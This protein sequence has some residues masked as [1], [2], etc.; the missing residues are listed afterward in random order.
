MNNGYKVGSK[1]VEKGKVFRVFK[2]EDANINGKKDKIIHYL[3][4]FKNIT[5][6][7]L[8]CS[9]PESSIGTTLLRKP[10][11]KEKIN[12]V[13]AGLSKRT[14]YV[15]PVDAVVAKTKLNLNDIDITARVLRKYWLVKKKNVDTF[16]KTKRDVLD[17]AVDRLV[18][19]VAYVVGISLTKAEEKIKVALK[20]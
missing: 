3:P 8:T 16:T 13:L 17:M 14:R 10:V 18:E 20:S 1:L 15:N 2:V 6:N 9:I 7:T 12:E 4:L 11:S 5:N 19:E